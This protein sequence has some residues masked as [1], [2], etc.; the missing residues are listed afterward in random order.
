MTELNDQLKQQGIPA[1]MIVRNGQGKQFG[2]VQG[3]AQEDADL[4]I[5]MS[6]DDANFGRV[7]KYVGEKLIVPEDLLQKVN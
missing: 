3:S 2:I 6:A 4:M 5:H 1:V 7:V